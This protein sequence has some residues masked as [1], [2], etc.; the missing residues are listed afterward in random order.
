[1]SWGSI[2]ER[3]KNFL[4][5]CCGGGGDAGGDGGGP[6]MTVGDA[7]FQ[8]ASPAQGPRAGYDPI[9]GKAM[10]KRQEA[11]TRRNVKEGYKQP[12]AE[13]NLKQGYKQHD[14]AK[15]RKDERKAE[16]VIDY[17]YEMLRGTGGHDDAARDIGGKAVETI[18]DAGN[19]RSP[20]EK[21]ARSYERRNRMAGKKKG[22]TKD[23]SVMSKNSSKGGMAEED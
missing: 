3:K 7:G 1:M 12:N 17:N 23:I 13:K 8:S 2:E 16:K 11:R 19:W 22:Y 9:L 6:T 10:R 15:S 5:D 14:N 18:G 20:D 21:R 4:E